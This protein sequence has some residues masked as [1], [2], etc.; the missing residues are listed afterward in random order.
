MVD[1]HVADSG[2]STV[3]HDARVE[4]FDPTVTQTA[5]LSAATRR[6]WFAMRAAAVVVLVAS[7]VLASGTATEIH[8]GPPLAVFG[9]VILSQLLQVRVRTAGGLLMLG[10]GEAAAVAACYLLPAGL[11]PVVY[12]GGVT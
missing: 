10:W 8:P 6:L 3:A 2:G 1:K 4:G 12:L 7:V 11:V 5:G 9:L